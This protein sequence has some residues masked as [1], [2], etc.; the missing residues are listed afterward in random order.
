MFAKFVQTLKMSN[1]KE[2]KSDLAKAKKDLILA[3]SEV[4]A[5]KMRIA[6]LRREISVANPIKLVYEIKKC[7]VD[8][9][10]KAIPVLMSSIVR[11]V[12]SKM[13]IEVGREVKNKLVSTLSRMYKNGEIG[14][15]EYDGYIYY[16]LPE[17]FEEN[18]KTL[19]PRVRAILDI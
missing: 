4:T 14:K 8:E 16:G 10:N 5:L 2:L 17:L 9:N 6:R 3:E 1:L 19:K 12:E 13:G 11:S 18:K 15:A 7:L